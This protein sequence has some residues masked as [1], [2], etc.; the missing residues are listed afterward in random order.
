MQL[1]LIT[2]PYARLIKNE[3]VEVK[4]MGPPLDNFDYFTYEFDDTP[5]RLEQRKLKI[6]KIRENIEKNKKG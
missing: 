5:W 4:P 1:P 2:K 6:A 3:L